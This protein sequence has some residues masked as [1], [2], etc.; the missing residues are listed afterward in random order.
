MRKSSACP[1]QVLNRRGAKFSMKF[2]FLRFPIFACASFAVAA[3]DSST[4]DSG[5][6]SFYSAWEDS[7]PSL[8][9]WCCLANESEEDWFVYVDAI[10]KIAPVFDVDPECDADMKK[11]D[12]LFDFKEESY[13]PT[14]VFWV[15]R[16]Y[17]A[18]HGTVIGLDGLLDKWSW[19]SIP[20]QGNT[21]RGTVPV[22]A[23]NW[24]RWVETSGGPVTNGLESA[25]GDGLQ[26]RIDWI[27]TNL[28]LSVE[29]VSSN[30]CLLHVYPEGVNGNPSFGDDDSRSFGPF[31]LSANVSIGPPP[32]LRQIVRT[33]GPVPRGIYRVLH[34]RPAPVEARSQAFFF[35][36][37]RPTC[38]PSPGTIVRCT[39]DFY[40]FVIYPFGAPGETNRAVES[41]QRGLHMSLSTNITV[42]V[43]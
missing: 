15:Q 41:C 34:G 14:N 25:D 13:I 3:T 8:R 18:R 1:R 17:P 28:V 9:L 10:G 24:K 29:N 22:R 16:L 11:G 12:V 36:A 38:T 2:H 20:P 4:T 35:G 6:F 33:G 7:G 21:T 40:P 39:M 26:W 42:R 37:V 43:E 32:N 19:H 31:L 30:P 27:G 5:P 23:V